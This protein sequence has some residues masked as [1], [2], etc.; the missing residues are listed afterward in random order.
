MY[1]TSFRNG[2]A[3]PRH[4]RR[5]LLQQN[6]PTAEISALSE[7]AA[8]KEGSHSSEKEGSHFPVAA[9]DLAFGYPAT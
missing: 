4:L 3:D 5:R 1:G 6:L 9:S 2:F 8:E 7:A